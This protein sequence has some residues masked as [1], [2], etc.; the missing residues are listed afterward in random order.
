[1]FSLYKWKKWLIS[2]IPLI[3]KKQSETKMTLYLKSGT[4]IKQDQPAQNTIWVQTHAN[5][6]QIS[7]IRIRAEILSL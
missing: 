3:I 7:W 6:T 5:S 2:K 4:Q 1:M